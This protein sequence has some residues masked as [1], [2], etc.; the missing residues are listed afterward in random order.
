M[1]KKFEEETR[2]TTGNDFVECLV[3][4]ENTG[5]VMTGELTDEAEE[6]KVSYSL[7]CICTGSYTSVFLTVFNEPVCLTFI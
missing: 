3:Y 6:D 1:I 2:K 7:V 4:S 5:V